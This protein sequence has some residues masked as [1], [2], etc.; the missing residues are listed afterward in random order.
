M[1]ITNKFNL[2]KFLVDIV[3]NNEHVHNPL[4]YGVTSV[5]SPIRETILRRKFEKELSEDINDMINMIFGSAFHDFMEKNDKSDA[6]KEYKISIKVPETERLLTGIIDR[7]DQNNFTV[8]DYKTTTTYKVIEQDFKD[9]KMQGLMY[10]WLLKQEKKHVEKITFQLFLKDF[11][12]SRSER[13]ENYPDSAYYEWTYTIQP[14][15]LND[16]E[17]YIT[18]RMKR[19]QLN[20]SLPN[21]L[22]DM[23]SDEERWYTGNSYAIM[24]LGKT[25]AERVFNTM[26]EALDYSYKKAP[27]SVIQER[28]GI[29]RKCEQYCSVRH[30]CPFGK[31]I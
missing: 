12:K 22:L 11:S 15:D 20:E 3:E 21:E 25:K 14:N 8:Y 19:L 1:N 31:K 16:I 6:L 17:I 13:T 5:L 2:P 10:A 29:Y 7:Y 18:E 27:N 30:I 26:Q 28:K 9:Y 23:C 24:K 4:S